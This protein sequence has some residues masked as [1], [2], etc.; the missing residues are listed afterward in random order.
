[1]SGR[2]LTVNYHLTSAQSMGA[3]FTSA[4]FNIGLYDD[5]YIQMNCVGTPSGTF[6]VQVSGD[7]QVQSGVVLSAG[8][9]V[10][11]ALP[12]VPTCAG[13][14]IYLGVNLQLT[15]FPWFQIVYTRTGGTGTCDIWVNAKMV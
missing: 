15:G 2:K 5:A 3:S 12:Q 10:S 4:P 1:M 6:D 14:T 7:R 8:N 9:F 11:L 13:A